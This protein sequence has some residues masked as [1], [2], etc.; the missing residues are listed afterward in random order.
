MSRHGRSLPAGSEASAGLGATS[1]LF[2]GSVSSV[3]S[4][5]AGQ[6]LHPPNDEEAQLFASASACSVITSYAD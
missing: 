2:E 5:D 3:T 1:E 4:P 6:V